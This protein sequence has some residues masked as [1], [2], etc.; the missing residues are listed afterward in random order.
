[1]RTVAILI[2]AALACIPHLVVAA[3]TFEDKP[4]VVTTTT[5]LGS[6][7]RDL[8]GDLVVVE[9][10]ASPA[11]CPAHYDVRPSDVEAFRRA[12][13]ILAHGMEPWVDVLREAS[14]ARAPLVAVRGPWNTPTALRRVY[15]SVA[16]AL[17]DNLGIDVSA[18]LQQSLRAINE[19]ESWL[20]SFA[21]ENGFTGKP[22]VAMRWQAPFLSFL[23]FRV[24]ATYGPPET[25]TAREYEEVIAN[26]TREKAILVVDNLQSGTELGE[27]VARRIGAVHVV[28]TNFPMALPDVANVT[29]VMR[30]NA[31]LLAKALSEAL[32][33][34]LLRDEIARLRGEVELL[35]G[36]VVALGGL[37]AALAVATTASA[38]RLRRARG[39]R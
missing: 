33:E 11:A 25:V 32:N 20:K 27:E 21:A 3:S 26:A 37:A 30:Y 38:V 24:V 31:M 36:S 35:R 4:L 9:V 15:E 23:G 16:K 8:A 10:I 13:L 2:V 39:G 22:V 6:V 34:A 14:G 5:V 1:M 18:R 29:E 28:L 7:V 19:T 12:D 17:A